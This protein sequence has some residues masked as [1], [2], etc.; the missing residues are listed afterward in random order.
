MLINTKHFGQVDL[1]ENKILHFDNG[2][3]GF[4]DYKQYT[5]LYDSEDGDKPVISWLQSLDDVS[6]ALPVIHPFIVM[7]NYNP[8]IEDE[9]IKPLGE[10]TPDNLIIFVSITVPAD[11]TKLTANMKAPFILNMDTKKGAQV[12]AENS[13]YQIKYPIYQKLKEAKEGK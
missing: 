3:L 5:L 11:V 2:I 10:L 13:D 6:L 8:E 7:E 9:L 1:D 12:I 4:E